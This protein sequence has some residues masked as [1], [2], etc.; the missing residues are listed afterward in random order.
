MCGGNFPN[1]VCYLQQVHNLHTVE[2]ESV[3]IMLEG[4]YVRII[5]SLGPFLSSI[6]YGVPIATTFMGKASE[7]LKNQLKMDWY[8]LSSGTHG[9]QAV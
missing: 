9:P 2:G 8:R 4:Y 7:Q 5:W 3:M 6:P 1:I